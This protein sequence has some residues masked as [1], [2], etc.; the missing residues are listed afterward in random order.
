[1]QMYGLAAAA[2]AAAVKAQMR[3]LARGLDLLEPAAMAVAGRME[4]PGG[5]RPP[6]VDMPEAS[7]IRQVPVVAAAWAQPV[8]TAPPRHQAPVAL[9]SS[10]P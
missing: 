4:G 10:L 1:M 9:V 2:A 8:P 3:L 6:L 5:V 7:R